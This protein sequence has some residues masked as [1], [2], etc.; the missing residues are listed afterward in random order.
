MNI[1]RVLLIII[2]S[3]LFV[4]GT[5]AI[6]IPILPTFPFYLG[7]FY[8]YARSS[9]RL[10]NWFIGTNLYKNNLESYIEGRGMTRDAKKRV[11]ISLSIIFIFGILVMSLKKLY[12][13]VGVLLFIWLF[14]IYYFIFRVSTIKESENRS[15]EFIEEDM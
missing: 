10:H 3:I 5:I 12:I 7:T 9:K 13:P 2:G 1:K 8:C 15:I 6:A 14:H 11:I 4:I